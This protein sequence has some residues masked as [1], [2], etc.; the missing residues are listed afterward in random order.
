M[1]T[2]V[3]ILDHALAAHDAGLSVVPPAEDGT[4]RPFGPWAEYQEHRASKG[5]ISAWYSRGRTGLGI[6][7]GK[8]SGNLET[9]EFDDY[10]TY[11]AYKA[12]ADTSGLGE[13]VRQIEAGFLEQSPSDGIH[14]EYRCSEIG[15]NTKLA[16]RLKNPEEMKDAG[17]K[18]KVLIET[19]GEGGF[20][21][22]APSNGK[23]HPTGKPYRLLSGSF[24]TIA[25]I[26]PD[27]RND[28]WHLA[29][30]FDQMPAGADPEAVK[31]PSPVANGRPGDDY[32]DNAQW[33]A[34]LPTHGWVEV[35]ESGGVTY[36]RR[37]GKTQGI[38]ATTNFQNSDLLYVFSTSTEFE[39]ERGYSKFGAY[40]L[41]EHGGD[42]NAAARVLAGEGFGERSQL[43][44][45]EPEANGDGTV[46]VHP[47]RFRSAAEI[48]ASTLVNTEYISEPWVAA[49][50]M[51]EL[52]GKIKQG[53]KTTFVMAMCRKVLDGLPFMGK[54]TTKT[55]VVY[56]TE[57][58]NA[59]LR[60]ALARADLLERTDFQVLSYKDAFGRSW[61][62]IV[63]AAA[64]KCK[65]ADARLLVVD[66]VPQW[67]GL[68]GTSENDSGAA[69]EALRPLQVLAGRGIGV[70][71]IRHD[72]KAERAVGDSGR[73]S[74]AWGGG[75][76][77]IIS[78][79]RPEG[80]SSPTTRV[81][82]CIG[83]FDELPEKL[84]I[85][86]N[87][88]TGEYRVI[89]TETQLAV[90]DAVRAVKDNAPRSEDEA[91][92]ESDLFKEAEIKRTTG[93]DAVETL[94]NQGD[95][96]AVGKG[97]KGDPVRYWAPKKDSDAT[98]GSSDRMNS[99]PTDPSTPENAGE[100]E[101]FILSPIGNGVPSESI[102]ESQPCE[103][104]VVANE[105]EKDGNQPEIHSVATP[106][107]IATETNKDREVEV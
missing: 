5:Q 35:Y 2:E 4:K 85:D 46:T 15:G 92:K 99:E 45:S 23:V 91:L 81:L 40:S 37:P 52:D 94:V 28:L 102:S 66:T 60:A 19:R 84:V 100:Q 49:E 80:N 105:S 1:V 10:D 106:T 39:S 95:L 55:S 58:N 59:S 26:T 7:Q 53:G 64:Q 3:R 63:E 88:N 69:L 87:T 74:S 98:P 93:R 16:R 33:Q 27:E 77:I 97:V 90:L 25:T 82:H 42:F 29:R 89:G 79:R 83:R 61:P 9:L 57:Q 34:I 20:L 48:A 6:V 75:V 21:I 17:D 54:P 38:S 65:E 56:L 43:K 11:L 67:A 107:L 31:A 36:W 13:L 71:C 96:K 30:T 14:W 24:S 78:I 51:T 70:V 47:L 101:K 103:E 8:V 41:L 32:N 72:G 86:L 12:L 50:S 62:E 76:D 73:G 22:V 68:R 104:V 18:I 44:P